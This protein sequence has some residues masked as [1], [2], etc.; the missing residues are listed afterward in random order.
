LPA[1]GGCFPPPERRFTP[2]GPDRYKLVE[3][4]GDFTENGGPHLRIG[5]SNGQANFRACKPVRHPR[6]VEC[7]ELLLNALE[8]SPKSPFLRL[9]APM[10]PLREFKRIAKMLDAYPQVV[11]LRIAHA[12]QA[13]P[14]PQ[15]HP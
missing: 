4:G 5:Q 10:Q 1:S 13:V 2:I 11:A 7:A 12:R 6:V 14:F 15:P 3:L 8:R 9:H